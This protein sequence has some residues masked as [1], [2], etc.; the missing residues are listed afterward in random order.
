MILIYITISKISKD[1]IIIITPRNCVQR[2]MQHNKLANTSN[3]T[4]GISLTE[5]A[6]NIGVKASPHITA[7]ILP[8][9]LLLSDMHVHM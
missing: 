4:Y 9:S 7:N 6:S 8:R 1:T 2:T 3:T 5:L